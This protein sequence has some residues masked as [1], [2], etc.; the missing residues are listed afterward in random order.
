MIKIRKIR[1]K[2]NLRKFVK[3]PWELYQGN[4]HWVPPLISDTEHLLTPG[5]NPFWENAERELFLAYDEDEIVGRVAA[6]I[7][8][9]H[10][11]TYGEKTGFFGFYESID[12]QEVASALYGAAEEWLAEKGM[13]H[14]RG[15]MNPNINEEFGFVVKGFDQ[16]P[17]VMMPYTLPYYLRLVESQGFKKV[18]DVH[19]YWADVAAGMPEKVA[20]IAAMLKKRYKI[21]VRA[22]NMKELEEE[23]ALIKDVHDEAWKDNWGAV[24]FT[25][26][27]FEHIVKQLKTIAISDLVPIVELEGKVVAMGVAVP[28]ANQILRLANGRLFPFGFIKVLLNQNKVN[29][30]R[31][32]IL[33]VLSRYRRYGFDALLYHSI[34]E[35]ARKH[36]FTGGE[37]SWILEDNVEMIR[38]IEGWGG[39][40]TKIY[41]LYQKPI[42]PMDPKRKKWDWLL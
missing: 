37:F 30:V 8:A 25:Q 3:L 4:P 12:D 7:S 38:I 22:I 28:D 2:K 19:A 11:K 15:P 10:N 27:E 17:F 35:A 18:K 6:I 26:A 1:S 36:G 34:Y 39:K 21:T 20:R 42:K 13:R 23:A 41:R 31:I 5:R 14:M 9:N 16:D 40:L 24:A 29:R 32:L 33:G